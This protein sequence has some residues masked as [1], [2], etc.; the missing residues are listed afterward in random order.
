VNSGTQ[1]Q[2][3]YYAANGTALTATSSIFLA[4]TGNVGVGTTSPG[5]ALD[6]NGS[7]RGSAFVVT[8]SSTAFSTIT[9]FGGFNG[10]VSV[11]GGL[12]TGG[13]DSVLSAQRLTAYGNLTNIG[14]IQAG[15]LNLTSGGTFAAK[16]DYTT[17]SSPQ[18]VVIGDVN[19]DD[20]PDLIS[21][22]STGANVSVFI[23][24]GN[25]TFAAKTDY[26]T[27]SGPTGLA[28]GDVNGD[29]KADLISA[30]YQAGAGTTV[31]VFINNGNG[32]FATRINYTTAAGP[33]A[34]AVKDLNG[35]G[36]IDIVTSN[37]ASNNISV[38]L[39]RGNGTFG[40]KTDYT[41]GTA[42]YKVALGDMNGDGATDIATANY[43]GPS[44]SVFLNNGSGAFAAKVDYTTGTN[45]EG[46]VIGDVN[47]DGKS[48]IVT[49]N[50]GGPSA[51]V[52]LNNGGGTF[53]T[54]VDYTTNS[55]TSNIALGDVNGDGKNDFVITSTS[56]GVSSVL[57]NSGDGT[58]AAKVDYT[59]PVGSV[60]VAVGDL[61]ND[62]KAD[63]VTANGITASLSVLLN[64][65]APSLYVQG[66]T[67]NTVLGTTSP[68][69]KLSI[70]SSYGSQ[71]GL[72]DIASTTG[73][74]GSATTSL[75]R[76]N[77][78]GNI[79]IGTS[80]PFAKL[81]LQGTYA[82]QTP[83]LDVAS[84][85]NASGSATSSLFR[86]AANGNVGIGTS[87][88]FA[89]L[90]IVSST[91]VASGY[92]PAQ[93]ISVVDNNTSAT[94]YSAGLMVENILGG[95][96]G[97][98]Y[99]VLGST[100]VTSGNSTATGI[101]GF[102]D[103]S[104]GSD[105]GVYG[106]GGNYGV[107]GSNNVWGV[108]AE[109]TGTTNGGAALGVFSR[110]I[111]ADDLAYIW[112]DTSSFFG[113]ALELDMAG[114]S[115][116]FTGNLI[117]ASNNLLPRFTVNANGS[118]I[119]G[120]TSPYAKLSVQN[121]YGSSTMLFDVATT[122][123]AGY[124]TSSLFRIGANGNVA[125][126]SNT[127]SQN[128]GFNVGTTTYLAGGTTTAQN[129]IQLQGGC[130][131]I[132]GTCLS[133]GGSGASTTLLVNN[134]T[135]SGFNT[136]IGASTTLQN[137]TALK[138]TT[139]NATSTSLAV[140]GSATSTF[141][142]GINLTNGGCFAVGGACISA[143]AAAAAG[144]T[145]AVQ[146]A[147]GAIMSGDNTQFFFDNT[148]KALAIGT[149]TAYAKLSV[150]GAS[151]SIQNLFDIA[152]STNASGSATTSLFRVA[153]DGRV[154]VVP[155]SSSLVKAR[156]TSR[157]NASRFVTLTYGPIEP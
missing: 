123:S 67:G 150:Q 15:E 85:T 89:K 148:A 121:A 23:N 136:F 56:A 26:T 63:I 55:G 39:N 14:S 138:S 12:G 29:G 155:S 96:T 57:L 47:G 73:S 125:I 137:F 157:A 66:S 152:S 130:F 143:G 107:F 131:A 106:T 119:I 19:G 108:G 6:V 144:G 52:L 50:N 8:A 44:V 93:Y 140:T 117:I 49:A 22:N 43:S 149:T 1:G 64:N 146:F 112:H 30:N 151:G 153:Y 132:A 109:Y 115:G 92:S 95:S 4:A 5:A 76:V 99:G 40:V 61:N 145:G 90:S 87:S 139:T 105:Y 104:G 62:G 16:T 134:N 45:P 79:G 25:G 75:F 70:Q 97:S 68:W 69:A 33:R 111:T 94:A 101:L 28:I 48:D 71:I 37:F 7:I 86:I 141:A 31:S 124:A 120:S 133:S 127:P 129:G 41:T 20:R 78:N 100:L 74:N 32:T 3:P 17:A 154:S 142:A 53:A 72:F 18:S 38:L 81:T 128:F 58:F 21:V 110:T 102:R 11:S 59:T 126:A 103:R 13:N 82:N 36:K 80:T 156:T 98:R 2:L 116:S 65:V 35:D 24:N 118:T 27:G 9:S 46:V 113:N 84:S 77:A 34:V 10:Y 122:T 54:K 51:S 91:S 135:F 60:G 88:P 83:L 42:P 114:G 147:V